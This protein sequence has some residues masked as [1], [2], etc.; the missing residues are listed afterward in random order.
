M[1]PATASIEAINT[2][3]RLRTAFAALE[4]P[5]IDAGLRVS[6]SAGIATHDPAEPLDSVIERADQ[7]MY[8]A[9]ATGRNRVCDS[10][11]EL[12]AMG[13]LAHSTTLIR[14]A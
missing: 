10:P 1:M 8:A 12:D 6:F 14:A 13:S 4:W 2:I 9:K 7:C 3:D 5:T 11:L